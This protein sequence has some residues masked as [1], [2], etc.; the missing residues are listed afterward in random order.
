MAIQ[1]MNVRI[2]GIDY[3]LQ[4]NP[5]SVDPFNEYRKAMKAITNKRLKTEDDLIELGNIEVESKLYFSDELGVYVPSRW[6]SEAICTA[7]YAI[8]KVA[9][10]KARG[11][12]F[13]AEHEIK[14][15]YDNENLVKGISDIVKN[16]VFRHRA[17]L[18][19]GEIRV[20][21][22]FPIFKNWWFETVIEYDD[23]VIDF[24][25]LKS[26][27]ERTSMYGGFGDFRPTFGRAKAEVINV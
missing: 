12:V 13:I 7:C 26:V 3:L 19:Q 25:S 6:L 8:V 2:S 1:Q 17:I 15:H 22:D 23:S 14:L 27:I 4:N 5:Q 16:K 20:T 21:K 9:K 18:K 24:G 10:K 11:G